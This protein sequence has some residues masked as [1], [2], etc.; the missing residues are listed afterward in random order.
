[1]AFGDVN[2]SE[3]QIRGNHNPGAGGW[4][5]IKYFNKDTGYDGAPYP[6]KTDKAM[7][8]ELGDEEMM[9]A[10]VE[11]MGATSLCSIKTGEGCI[12]KEKTYIEKFKSKT[13]EEAAAE[14]SRL[15]SMAGNKLK[16]ELKK[17]ISQ[18]KAILKQMTASAKEEL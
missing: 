1:M 9:R 16:P 4:P 10:Y 5:T 13:A 18:R 8:E 17:W 15:S 14:Y 11:E 2:L 12:E 6:K 7:C 3:E